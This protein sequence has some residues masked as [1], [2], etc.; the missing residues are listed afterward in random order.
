MY[1]INIITPQ[2][3][4][5]GNRGSAAAP[6]LLQ[7][8]QAERGRRRWVRN[9]ACWHLPKRPLRPW[10]CRGIETLQHVC[11][12]CAGVKA[13]PVRLSSGRSVFVGALTLDLQR[14]VIEIVARRAGDFC[15]EPHRDLGRQFGEQQAQ[16]AQAFAAVFL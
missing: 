12:L 9:G 16:N 10:K 2:P 14:R 15:S 7:R 3:S 5:S 6:V 11:G 13:E 4:A 1:G 8:W